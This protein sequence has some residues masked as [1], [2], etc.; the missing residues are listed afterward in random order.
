[1]RFVDSLFPFPFRIALRFYTE[2]FGMTLLRKRDVP[3]DKYSSA[4]LGFGL[5]ESTFVVELIHSTSIL[6]QRCNI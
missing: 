5:E 2:A 3:K 4:V 1:M 6:Y